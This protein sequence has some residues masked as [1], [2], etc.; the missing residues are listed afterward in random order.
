MSGVKRP[1]AKRPAYLQVL[2]DPVAPAQMEMAE[3]GPK[4]PSR[5]DQVPILPGAEEKHQEA[6]A[7]VWNEL[8]EQAP[9]NV[10]RE[11]NWSIFEVLVRATVQYREASAQVLKYGAVIKSPSGYPIQSPYV[12][13]MNKQAQIM[14]RSSADLG[15]TL[16]SRLRVKAGSK[17]ASKANPFAGLKSLED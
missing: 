3:A 15:L 11:M 17:P 7:T 6:F 13:H 8:L 5:A 9:P 10:V 14:Q 4:V 12:S 1:S 2:Q 16:A